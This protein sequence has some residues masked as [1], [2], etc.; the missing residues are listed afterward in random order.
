M[1]LP[2]TKRGIVY[3]SWRDGSD[4]Y[5]DSKGFYIIQWDTTK[6][7]EYKK[8]LP[9]SWKP[10]QIENLPKK[11][12]STTTKKRTKKSTITKKRKST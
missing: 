4:I 2:R 7:Q 11:R 3:D 1:P 8:Y 10:V 5:K 12:K 6:E 9:K